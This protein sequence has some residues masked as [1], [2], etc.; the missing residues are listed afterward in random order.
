MWIPALIAAGDKQ[1]FAV[2]PVDKPGCFID[3]LNNAI[4]GWPCGT[5][6][7][8]ALRQIRRLHPIA[9][10]VSFKLG[11][12][13]LKTPTSTLGYVR[14]A[15]TSV[16]RPIY[17]ADTPDQLPQ[18]AQ[19]I[20]TPGAT[21]R[22]CSATEFPTYAGMMHDISGLA[23]SLHVPAIP[24]IQW[25]CSDRICPTIV[26]HTLVTHDGD[27]LTMEYSAELGPLLGRELRPILAHR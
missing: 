17:L 11:N 22:S 15:L 14:A 16:P 12:R 5:W 13:L 3:R 7:R 10:I 8:W 27:H 23:H 4:A 1:G 9:T 6:H 2:V 25:F 19:C 21:M 24:T 18:P 20:T 26:D